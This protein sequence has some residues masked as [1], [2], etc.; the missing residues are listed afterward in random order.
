MVKIH[1]YLSLLNKINQHLSPTVS[2]ASTK[3]KIN[4]LHNKITVKL[5]SGATRHYFKN[6]HRHILTDLKKLQNGPLAQLPDNSY[7]KATYEGLLQL[8]PS[9]SDTAKKVLVYPQVT[10]ESLLTLSS[11]EP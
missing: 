1:T 2:V 11:P 10:N 8:H 4:H 3:Q 6:E 7:V 9:L 5:D